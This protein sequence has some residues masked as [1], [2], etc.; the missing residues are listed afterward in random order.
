MPSGYASAS[1][2]SRTI[3]ITAAGEIVDG[4]FALTAT[5]AAG[6][7]LPATG[8]NS[9]IAVYGLVLIVVGVALLGLARRR[10][11]V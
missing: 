3:T 8:A 5:A 11:L 1:P 9:E 4:D 7:S 10:R 2:V 6:A